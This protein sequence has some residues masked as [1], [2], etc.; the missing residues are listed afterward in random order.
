[1]GALGL[2]Q[3][4]PDG[5]ALLDEQLCIRWHNNPFAKLLPNHPDYTGQPLQ[6]ALAPADG[7]DLSRV[8]LP[9]PGAPPIQITIRREDK[10]VLAL[11]IARTPRSQPLR[12]PFCS[13]S[14]ISPGPLRKSRN[15]KPSTAPDSNSATSRPTKSRK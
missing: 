11:H 7:T 3:L 12:P 6:Q 8:G 14:E 1:M 2:F 5:V 10:T 13:H 9:D 15:R 4:L